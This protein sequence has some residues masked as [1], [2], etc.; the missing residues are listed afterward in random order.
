MI[1]TITPRFSWFR[2]LRIKSE[3]RTGLIRR[4]LWIVPRLPESMENQTAGFPQPPWINWKT[5]SNLPTAAWI[6]AQ[7][8]AQ[9][10]T[11]STRIR[12]LF[13]DLFL[14]KILKTFRKEEILLLKRV[15]KQMSFWIHFQLLPEQNSS[16]LTTGDGLAD[17]DVFLYHLKLNSDCSYDISNISENSVYTLF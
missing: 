6:T 4:A 16:S 10:P 1:E 3:K 17:T 12:R 7:K 8:A 9:L 14:K 2:A 11:L 5:A 13:T 15:R